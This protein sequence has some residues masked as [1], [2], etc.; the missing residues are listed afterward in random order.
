MKKLAYTILNG[1]LLLTGN[2]VADD[3]A[4]IDGRNISLEK[5][6][7]D[8]S[9]E[10]AF[11]ISAKSDW[12]Q[13]A[14]IDKRT[15]NRN[16]VKFCNTNV[17][18]TAV[19]YYNKHCEEGL[20]L[21]LAYDHTHFNWNKNLYFHRQNFDNAILSVTGFSNRLCGW[22]WRGQVNINWDTRYQNI[23]EYTN[24]D[25]FLWGRYEYNCQMNLH[26]GFFA[27]TGMKIDRV[28]P[29]LGFDWTLSPT[30]KV[31]AVF[32]LNISLVYS[33]NQELTGSLAVRL[34]NLRYRVG[35]HE[36]L[37]K[38]LLEYRNQGIE[39]AVNYDGKRLI[40]NLHGGYALGGK[41]TISNQ[42]HKHKK[43]FNFDG[44]AYIG[45]ELGIKF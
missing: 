31:N 2:L 33:Y 13:E 4:T 22:L 32:P 17:E 5:I 11:Q 44:S 21:G 18:A 10:T 34:F 3:D 38:G 1:I 43:H 20:A 6:T 30:W 7:E 37:P 35:N 12:I 28:Y 41:F 40:A 27:L 39:L 23:S 8:L 14:K 36:P 24:Y 16:H 45:G 19:V 42:H 9:D 25:I 29:I 15:F 26:F